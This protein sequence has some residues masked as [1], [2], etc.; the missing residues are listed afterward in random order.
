[1]AAKKIAVIGAGLGGLAAAARLASSGHDVTIYESAS[2]PGG[3]A[4]EIRSDNFR[5]DAGPSL[6]TMPFVLEELF[7]SCDENI[8]DYLRLSKLEVICRYIF[9]DGEV[10]NAFSDPRKFAA[11]IEE[12]TGT[13]S[14]DVIKYLQ[15]SGKIYDLTADLFLNK[16]FSE[17]STLISRSSLKTLLSIHKID[18]FRTMHKANSSFFKSERIVQLFDRYATYNGSNP[19]RAPATLNIIQHVEYNLGAYLPEGGIHSITSA[20]HRLCEKKGV[21]FRFSS[22]VEEIIHSR[23]RV[24]GIRFKDAGGEISS[25]RYDIIISN[26]DVNKTYSGLL[27][28]EV[29]RFAKRYRKLEPSSSAMVFYW[30]INTVHRDLETHNILFSEDYRKEFDEIFDKKICPVD[31]TVYIYISSKM[32]QSDAPEGHQNWFTMINAPYDAGQDWDQELSRVRSAIIRK[33]KKLLN[34]DLNDHIVF[35]KILTP[36]E[37]EKM[38]GSRFGSL[39]GISSNNPMAAFLRQPN[40]SEKYKGLYFVGG[41]AHPGGGIPLVLLSGKIASELIEKYGDS[42]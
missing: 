13:P 25:A 28:D 10:I 16:S 7:D 32:N 38:T 33:V 31:P 41:S 35:E 42:E 9:P 24:E 36:P 4:S 17:F 2:K 8:N 12:K 19:F 20:L 37:I 40:R 18:P 3:K 11:E 34:I 14:K 1:M 23:K 26:A 27:G 22:Y 5:F 39:Y 29:S 30:G 21:E 6:L 15:Y